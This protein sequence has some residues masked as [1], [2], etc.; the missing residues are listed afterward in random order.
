MASGKK[1]KIVNPKTWKKYLEEKKPSKLIYLTWRF[2]L[3]SALFCRMYY[4]WK[5]QQ[6][7]KRKS[8]QK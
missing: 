5:R 7:T 3:V 6:K 2:I 4:Y 1:K 8:L